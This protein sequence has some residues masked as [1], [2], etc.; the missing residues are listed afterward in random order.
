LSV[1]TGCTSAE[2]IA[3]DEPDAYREVLKGMLPELPA[4]PSFPELSWSFHDGLYC[5]SESDVD[6]LL[7][8]GEN[9]MPL[10]K[11]ELGLYKRQLDIVLNQL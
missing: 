4:V 7:D 9:M 6:R 5:I 1:S 3:P 8:Y 11:S 2:A 10:L